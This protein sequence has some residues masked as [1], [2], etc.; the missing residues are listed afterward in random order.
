L[1][2]LT[3]EAGK[4]IQDNILASC[5]KRYSHES[6]HDYIAGDH[7]SCI[8]LKKHVEE[9]YDLIRTWIESVSENR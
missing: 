9:I 7:L 3:K 1:L 5:R 4:D 2:F 8:T 6:R